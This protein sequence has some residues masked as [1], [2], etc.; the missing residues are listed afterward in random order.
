MRF[1]VKVEIP[2]ETGNQTI[3][4]GTLPKKM[5]S[6]LAELKPE[7]AYFTT[8]NG[9]RTALLFL[10][11]QNPAQMVSVAEPFFLA[12]NATVEIIPA[13]NP[14]DLMKGGPAMEAAV[15]KYS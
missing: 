6:I 1:L 8:L 12:F 10:D 2:V 11:M 15:K 7:A 13:M 14:D 4:D 3:R 5:Q 9:R